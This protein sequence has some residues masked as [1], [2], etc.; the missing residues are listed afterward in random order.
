MVI[1]LAVIIC[2]YLWIIQFLIF[3]CLL[4][5][6]SKQIHMSEKQTFPLVAGRLRSFMPT[7]IVSSIS[8]TN[9]TIHKESIVNFAGSMKTRRLIRDIKE[10]KEC[11]VG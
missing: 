8:H 3:H 1:K 11:N 5:K 10:E 4:H 6:K 9:K 2:V 7:Y